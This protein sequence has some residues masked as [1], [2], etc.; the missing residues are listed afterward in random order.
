MKPTVDSKKVP[1]R[2][3]VRNCI[4]WSNKQNGFYA[5]HHL[6]GLDFTNNTAFHNTRNFNMVNRK[7]HQEAVDVEGYGHN[8]SNNVAYKPTLSGADCVNFDQNLSSASNNSFFSDLS[9]KDSDFESLDASQLLKPRNADGSLP[10]ITF[11]KLK[12]SSPAYGK[13]MGH[14]FHAKGSSPASEIAPDTKD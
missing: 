10:D 12:P 5:N 1:P 8:L 7:S 2:N 11:L 14:R 9:L 3:I 6:G 13:K 4:S